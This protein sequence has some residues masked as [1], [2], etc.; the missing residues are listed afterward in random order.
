MVPPKF[1]FRGFAIAIR[2]LSPPDDRLSSAS[3]AAAP[4]RGLHE[5]RATPNHVST[6]SARSPTLPFLASERTCPSAGSAPALHECKVMASPTSGVIDLTE[7]PPPLVNLPLTVARQPEA[8]PNVGPNDIVYTGTSG[9]EVAFLGVSRSGNVAGQAHRAESR[10]GAAV[11]EGSSRNVLGQ[12]HRSM[13]RIVRVADSACHSDDLSVDLRALRRA[14]SRTGGAPSSVVIHD[15]QPL[16]VR[17]NPAPAPPP[18][19][20]TTPPGHR[21]GGGGL[22]RGNRFSGILAGAHAV[23][24]QLWDAA[25]RGW[26]AGSSTGGNEADR[27][28]VGWSGTG[29]RGGRGPNPPLFRDSDFV[30]ALH[31]PEN[32]AV[33]YPWFQQELA[34][35]AG[36]E[37]AAAQSYT[38]KHS[39]PHKLQP[40]FARDV[41]PPDREILTL[42]PD[43]QTL[44]AGRENLRPLCASCERE[45][46]MGQDSASGRRPWIL[47]CG[48]VV[49]SRCLEAARQRAKDERGHRS[50]R[51]RAQRGGQGTRG[52]RGAAKGSVKAARGLRS[53]ASPS[54]ADL[55]EAT[56]GDA[57]SGTPMTAATRASQVAAGKKKAERV[58]QSWW[59]VCPVPDCDGEHGDLLARKGTR[60]SP[61]EM[62][63]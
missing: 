14:P 13:G 41:I 18:G 10:T 6:S 24:I 49:D 12:S 33:L 56:E 58:L 57:T 37:Q 35:R 46:C 25:A 62:F 26:A 47:A 27:V 38:A 31:H 39:H 44:R 40:G 15:A 17:A 48:H 52:R 23:G 29:R 42:D 5:R 22:F 59:T 54:G 11:G 16:R 7:S 63:L 55:P 21:L 61:W 30:D 45:L 36:D 9:P 19:T 28:I 60:A 51:G 1:D 43:T 2:L 50:T 20:R 3:A 8:A 34:S 53:V 32:A 4:R